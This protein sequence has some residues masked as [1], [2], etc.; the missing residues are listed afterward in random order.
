MTLI[1]R[2]ASLIAATFAVAVVMFPV[3]AEA[4]RLVG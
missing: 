4:A 1:Q 3:A 2:M